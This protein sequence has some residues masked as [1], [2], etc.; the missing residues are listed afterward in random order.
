[1]KIKIKIGVDGK[2]QIEVAEGSFAEAS[3]KVEQVYKVIG[4]TAKI[5]FASTPEQH[6]HD[7]SS[8]ESE[9]DHAH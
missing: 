5:E 4:S 9:H 8:T 1:M 2:I 6:R 7:G 3:E